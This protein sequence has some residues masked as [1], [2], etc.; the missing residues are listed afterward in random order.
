MAPDSAY[1]RSVVD[2]INSVR[3]NAERFK[4]CANISY[5]KISLQ[6]DDTLRSLMAEIG[7]NSIETYTLHFVPLTD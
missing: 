1:E 4:D 3:K 2:Q 5:N 7:R 6:N